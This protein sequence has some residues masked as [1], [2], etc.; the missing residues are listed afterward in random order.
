MDGSATVKHM[1]EMQWRRIDS[2][3]DGMVQTGTVVISNGKDRCRGAKKG[4][5]RALK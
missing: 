1:I 3:R 5:G 2:I 4:H